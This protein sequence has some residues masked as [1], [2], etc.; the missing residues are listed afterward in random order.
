LRPPEATERSRLSAARPHPQGIP[1]PMM[2]RLLAI[3][4]ILFCFEVGVLLFVLPWVSL[5]N[6]NFFVGHYPWIS[7]MAH[8]YFVRGAISGI[9]LADIWLAFFELWRFRKELGLVHRRLLG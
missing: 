8:N 3:L 7:T 6:K 9:G 1:D 5:W 2:N 4:Y